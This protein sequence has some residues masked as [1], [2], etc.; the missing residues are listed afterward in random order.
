MIELV[1]GRLKTVSY[2]VDNT[3]DRFIIKFLID[4]TLGDLKQKFNFEEIPKNLINTFIDIVVGK[5][6]LE[7]K[8]ISPEELKSIDLSLSGAIKQIN[9]GDVSVSYKDGAKTPEQRL[10]EF[11][12]ALVDKEKEFLHI[13]KIR[14]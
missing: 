6:L 12:F 11:I 9:E 4:K 10:D 7:K 8:S 5:F 2:T 1:I 14:W 3:S 13:R